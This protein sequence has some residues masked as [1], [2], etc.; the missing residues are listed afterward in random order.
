M[1]WGYNGT[2]QLGDNST[3]ESNVP[4]AV[5]GL[6]SGVAAISAGASH[7][8]ALTSAGGVMCWGDNVYGELG[9]N[10]GAESDVPVSV[11][12]AQ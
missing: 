12:W 3:T 2:G 10:S 7:T 6:S 8:C 11:I 5:S 9:N 4:V 1:C